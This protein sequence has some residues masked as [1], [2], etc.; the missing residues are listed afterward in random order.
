MS[1]KKQQLTLRGVDANIVSIDVIA[2]AGSSSGH[3]DFTGRWRRK[4]V[5]LADLFPLSTTAATFSRPR[6][7]LEGGVCRLNTP[8]A[9]KRWFEEQQ[10]RRFVIKKLD[11]VRRPVLLAAELQP[12][13]IG[14]TATQ[15]PE[16]LILSRN[17]SVIM[18]QLTWHPLS[19]AG[20]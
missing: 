10:L 16:T 18:V 14:L 9:A 2:L 15:Q 4:F 17:S 1:L 5:L 8:S 19:L 3:K 12:V 20:K 6:W 7:P 11:T 13:M